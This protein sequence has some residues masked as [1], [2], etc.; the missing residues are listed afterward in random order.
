M[1]VRHVL[2]GKKMFIKAKRFRR[3]QIGSNRFRSDKQLI[4]LMCA[5]CLFSL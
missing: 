2:S 3:K 1:K 4:Q 5:F